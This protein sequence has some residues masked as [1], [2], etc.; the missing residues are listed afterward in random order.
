MNTRMSLKGKIDKGRLMDLNIYNIYIKIIY[1]YLGKIRCEL[2]YI[3]VTLTRYH[4]HDMVSNTIYNI[5][6]YI[7]YKGRYLYGCMCVEI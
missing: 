2:R 3:S 4:C 5:L 7:Y 1:S 6:Y